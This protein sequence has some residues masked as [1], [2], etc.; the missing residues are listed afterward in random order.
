MP[1]YLNTIMKV[2]NVHWTL[3]RIPFNTILYSKYALCDYLLRTS[4]K[5]MQYP[6]L[7]QGICQQQN[8]CTHYHVCT[9]KI[10]R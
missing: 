1:V 6:F 8:V 5:C 3:S 2:N 7:A 4:L 10:D 9:Y